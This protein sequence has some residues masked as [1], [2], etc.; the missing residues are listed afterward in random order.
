MRIELSEDA[1]FELI[2]AKE[3]YRLGSKRKARAFADAVE[4]ALSL[5]ARF[6]DAG[7]AEE[8]VNVHV[9][10]DFPYE[11][12]YRRRAGLIEIIA[13]AHTSRR[14]GYWQSRL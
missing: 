1:E 7:R 3:F 9:V 12:I 14:P 13:I 2:E 4:N 5:L 11:V 10:K 8:G 6:P